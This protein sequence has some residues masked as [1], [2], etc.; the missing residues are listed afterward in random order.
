MLAMLH[1]EQ[2]YAF[3]PLYGKGITIIYIR[4][5]VMLLIE[6]LVFTRLR[7]LRIVLV[8]VHSHIN[9]SWVLEKHSPENRLNVSWS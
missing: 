8:R 6:L 9:P 3:D 7:C 5:R 4:I 2:W 1:L